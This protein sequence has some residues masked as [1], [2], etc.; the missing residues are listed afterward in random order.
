MNEI[1]GRMPLQ[2]GSADAVASSSQR[3]AAAV[4]PLTTRWV[5]DVDGWQALREIWDELLL[6]STDSTPWQSWDYL[7]NWWRHLGKGKELRILVV[8]RR[9]QPV[10]IFPLQ[11]TRELM[12]GIPT[13]MLEPISM[14]WDVNRP[15][16]ALGPF[17][18]EAYRVGLRAISALPD[19]DCLRVE[20]LPISDPQAQAMREFAEREGLW[21]RNVL[22]SICPH[23]SLEQTWAQFLQGRG[24]K[25]RKNLRAA[26]RRLEALGPVTFHVATT[27]A[28]IDRGLQ[29]MLDLHRRSWKRRKR[30]GLS[31]SEPYRAFF[32]SFL[33]A[34]ADRGA[35]RVLTLRCGGQAV[36]ATIAFTHL[37]TYF[38]AEIV[39]DARYAR[40]SPGT[41]LEAF[42]LEYLMNERR[43]RHYDF[44]GRFLN[45]KM[46]WT[47]QARVTH[48]IYVFRP[49]ARCWLLDLHYFRVKPWIKRYWRAVFGP[50][51]ATR[52]AMEFLQRS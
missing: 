1:A 50:S 25:L 44:L 30:V 21:F 39:H 5:T 2:V 49:T 40:C 14:L 22:S 23:L 52:Q 46:R 34:M 11:L 3:A 38:S 18:E 20:E 41:L 15:R 45:N 33:L 42:E 28:D 10:M 16:F 29:T 31:L 8:S 43:F 47:E 26:R 24:S 36:A 27:V 48:R 4:A 7:T 51:R 37:D 13:R 35:A 9:E 32:R 17:D 19:W 6:A 12:I